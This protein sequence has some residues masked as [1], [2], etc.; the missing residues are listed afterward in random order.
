MC[1]VTGGCCEQSVNVDTESVGVGV[2][3]LR[4]KSK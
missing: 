2:G 4:A 3:W 1:R